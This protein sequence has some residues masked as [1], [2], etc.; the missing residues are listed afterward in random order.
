M[1]SKEKIQSIKCVI[2]EFYHDL[3]CKGKLTN[4]ANNCWKQYQSFCDEILK[5]LDRL[6]KLEKVIKILKEYGLW[7]VDKV[8]LEPKEYELLKEVLT[9]EI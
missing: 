1:D 8:F 3:N 9:N 4:D 7:F 6:E 2:N 5:D